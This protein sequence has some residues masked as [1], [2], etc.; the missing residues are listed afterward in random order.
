MKSLQ[1]CKKATEILKKKQ[2]FKKQVIKLNQNAF[3]ILY[4]ITTKSDIYSNNIAFISITNLK[5]LS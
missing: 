3:N 2:N 1:D 4:Q 5:I